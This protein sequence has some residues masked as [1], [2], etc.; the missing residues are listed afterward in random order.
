MEKDLNK[1]IYE[2]SITSC[3]C[4]ENRNNRNA[5]D[6]NVMKLQFEPSKTF[7]KKNTD[8]K[9]YIPSNLQEKISQN[10]QYKERHDINQEKKTYKIPEFLKK[11]K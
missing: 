9:K 8:R 1:G 11:K 6:S 3:V 7:N 2:P 10:N 5:I 4:S